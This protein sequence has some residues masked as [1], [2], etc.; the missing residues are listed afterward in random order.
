[1]TPKPLV[2]G[3]AMSNLIGTGKNPYKLKLPREGRFHWYNK[4]ENVKGRKMGHINCAAKTPEQ[5][6]ELAL[7]A[8]SKVIL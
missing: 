4:K 2:D 1:M 8:R 5:A 3:F 6:L 7:K